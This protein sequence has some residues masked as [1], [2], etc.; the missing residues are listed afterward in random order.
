MATTLP[1]SPPAWLGRGALAAAILLYRRHVSGR[2]PLR[3]VSCTFGRCESCSAYGLRVVREHA[4]SL[5]DALRLVLGR[6][7]RCRS[8]SVHGHGRAL[9]WGEDY[10]RPDELDDLAARAHEQPRTR[11]ALLW[12]AIGVTGYRGERALAAR[13]RARSRALPGSV[14]ERVR[15]PLRRGKGLRAHLR[16]RWQRGL[17]ITLLLA[18]LG[19]LLPL[20]LALVL[21]AIAMLAAAAATRRFIGARRRLYAQLR[22]AGSRRPASSRSRCTVA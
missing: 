17:V 18:G 22:L 13:L 3:R 1:A 16:A 12:A 6:I 8:A 21:A 7:R 4:R 2:G 15:L 20:P 5:P 11:Q 9:S 14:S 19:L 10:D